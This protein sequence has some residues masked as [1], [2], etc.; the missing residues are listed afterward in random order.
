MRI[1]AFHRKHRRRHILISAVLAATA[2]IATATAAT[3][4]AGAAPTAVVVDTGGTALSHRA[5][6]RTG[7]LGV[8][9][10]FST[11]TLAGGPYENQSNRIDNLPMYQAATGSSDRFWDNYVEE[12]V[13]SGVDFVAMVTRGYVPGSA[14]PN[15]GGDPRAITGLVDAIRRGGYSDK[16]KVAAFDDTPASMTDKK[17]QV[18]HK[19]GGYSPVFDIGD[20]NGAGEGGY[21]YLWDNDLRAY[22]QSVPDDLRYKVD[23]QPV[24]YLWSNNTFAFSGQ[25]GGNS[26]R[27]LQH[28]R[29]QAQS[30]FGQ[31]PYF[32]VDNSW[33]KNDSAVTPVVNGANGWFGVPSPSYTNTTFNGQ[34]YGMG[35]PGFRFVSG[36]TNMVIDPDHGKTLVNNL[37]ATVNGGNR[38]T[39]FEGFTDWE[40]NASLWRTRNAPYSTTQ[41]DYP[42]QNLNILRRYSKDPFP[43]GMVVQAESADSVSDTTAGNLWG[44]YRDDDLDV[45]TTTDTGGGWNVGSAAAGEW[46][47]W[48]EVPMQGTENL[49]L[50]VATPNSGARLRFVVDGV[51]GPVVDVPSTG[52]WQTW[53]TIDAGTFQFSPGT[54]HTVQ[55]QQVAGGQNINWWRADRTAEPTGR[56][57]GYGG[58]CV[59]IAGAN[60]ADGTAV[61]LYTC[62]DSAAQTWTRAT[63]GS[64][65]ALGKCMD[66][67]GGATA[68]GTKVRLATCNGGGAQKWQPGASGTLVNPQ[69]GRCLD[70]T[71][72]SSADGTRL[73]IW[74]CAASANQKWA[75][76]A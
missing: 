23:G 33:L 75:L 61:Q 74:D 17:N 26:A 5:P 62:N 27:L 42:N 4:P 40:E 18:K 35:V 19:T 10:G 20:T 57:S 1:R 39:L 22:F 16:L 67:T 72:P 68:N 53:Q 24:V 8:T 50:R 2:G 15:Q 3:T 14:V 52:D 41:R 6:G 55:L 44:V 63:D 59:D 9:F 29:S 60:P 11:R 76:P 25:G 58:K 37:E 73:Q 34:S 12:L 21:Q 70:A 47:Q 36:S 30:E 48:R 54:H 46:M 65:K 45:Q 38:I 64:L 71:G 31:S 43:A 66:V 51:A 32:V 49:K 69:S 28:V 13:T 56:I 7:D